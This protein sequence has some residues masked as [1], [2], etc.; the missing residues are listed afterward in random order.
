MELVCM[1]FL[2]IEG[3]GN[4]KGNVLVVTDHFTHYA[5]AFAT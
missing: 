1:D 3:D 2:T 5:Q 4:Q